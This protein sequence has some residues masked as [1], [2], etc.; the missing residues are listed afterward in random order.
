[1]VAQDGRSSWNSECLW[2]TQ[3]SN[4]AAYIVPPVAHIGHGPAGISHY[5]GTG[6]GDRYRGHFFY[7]DF[8]G[9]V[10]TFRVEPD[11]AFFKVVQPADAGDSR[12]WIEDNSAAN[13]TGK[14]LW[15]LSP[16]DV[17]FPPFGGV[18]VADWVQGWEK[19]GKGRLWHITDPALAN[20]PQ[21]AEVRRLLADG[22]SKRP[23]AEL[24]GLLAHADQRV[25]LEAQWE[26]A[27][28]GAESFEG[29]KGV[30]LESKELLARVHALWGIG[31]LVRVDRSRDYAPELV[32][33]VGLLSDS[34]AEIRGT[35]GTRPRGSPTG[36]GG[37][38]NDFDRGRGRS[39]GRAGD[40][41]VAFPDPTGYRRTPAPAFPAAAR[42]A[43]L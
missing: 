7:A 33:M 31:H 18:V 14:L 11:G 15:E 39:R 23:E 41:G 2:H 37:A 8:P 9:G 38:G 5:P 29:L 1:M 21:I 17:T 36:Q 4:S 27:G 3:E 35:G 16:V 12:K 13:R 26:L 6:L 30:A 42:G 34:S 10:R 40:V 24:L 32:G 20:D 43:A 25:R 19:T 22:M 28:R